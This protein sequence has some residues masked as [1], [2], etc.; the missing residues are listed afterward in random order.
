MWTVHTSEAGTILFCQI[1]RLEWDLCLPVG[2]MVGVV[3]LGLWAILKVKRWRE[4]DVEIDSLSPAEQIDRYQE[5]VDDG[6]LD[7]QEFARIKARM[8][9]RAG[10]QTPESDETPPPPNQP[11]DISIQE[12]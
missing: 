8:E 2:A 6:L 7:P 12:K 1:G 9:T 11:P 10:S 4:E 3:V 5:M